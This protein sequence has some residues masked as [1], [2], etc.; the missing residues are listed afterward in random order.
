MRC[1]LGGYGGG[2]R[3]ISDVGGFFYQSGCVKIHWS[4]LLQPTS[5]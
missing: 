3:R 1:D 5:S 4:G 2:R